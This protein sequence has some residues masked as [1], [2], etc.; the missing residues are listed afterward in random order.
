MKASQV[1]KGVLGGVVIALAIVAIV[2]AY[3]AHEGWKQNCVHALH[4]VVQ[5]QTWSGYGYHTDPS[6]KM[7]Y[8]YYSTSTT[9]CR[10]TTGP[11]AG[12]I[13]DTE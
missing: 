11:N 4:G 1:W 3:R 10:L 8:G 12:T 6:G 2:Y 13:V 9:V 5:T 7:V